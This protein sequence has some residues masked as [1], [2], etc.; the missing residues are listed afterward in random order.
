MSEL[1]K[2]TKMQAFGNDFAIFDFRNEHIDTEFT[3]N[4]LII[5]TDR[6]FGIGCDQ[7]I[8][9]HKCQRPDDEKGVNVAI[10]IF[11][12]DGT[13]AMNCGN[14]IRCV[15]GYIARE[16]NKPLVRVQVGNKLMLGKPDRNTKYAKVNM[17][18]PTIDGDMVE[19]GNLHK[20]V[21]VDNFDN[22]DRMPNNE[23]NVQYVQV[24]SRTEVFM[25]SIERGSGETLSC[26]SGTC[27]VA[28]YCIANNLVDKN[29]KVFSR[30]SDIMDTSAEVS[31][32]GDGKPVLLGGNYTF[33]FTGEIEFGG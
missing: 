32:D 28:C 14:G 13:E 22:I 19:L 33:V 27:A 5:L 3:R 21:V 9:I 7:L 24:R 6:N 17:G 29:V 11:N 25:R 1:F 20:I 26:G 12:F 16:T 18:I 4:D 30:G 10:R 2:F 15:I 8:T 23:Y 31:W